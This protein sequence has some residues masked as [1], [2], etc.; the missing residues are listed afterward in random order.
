MATAEGG[1][2]PCSFAQNTWRRMFEEFQPQVWK[3]R[4]RDETERSAVVALTKLQPLLG[5]TLP[6]LGFRVCRSLRSSCID[7]HSS[8]FHPGRGC[9]VPRNGGKLR[10]QKV[11]VAEHL[12]VCLSVRQDLVFAFASAGA[13]KLAALVAWTTPS[14]YGR[15][16][17]TSAE[18]CLSI[19]R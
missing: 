14:K 19:I 1:Q 15:R 16:K 8:V 3:R 18:C 9:G 11:G 10:H 13:R 7:R 6:S 2:S 12:A 4:I 17:G 5:R